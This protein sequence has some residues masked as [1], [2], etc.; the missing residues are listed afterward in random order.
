MTRFSRVLLAASL[1][2]LVGVA[3]VFAG[4]SQ[5]SA[6]GGG[7]IIVRGAGFVRRARFA[8]CVLCARRAGCA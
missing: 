4:G 1:I 2:V 6:Q 8:L 5:E 7:T 3:G